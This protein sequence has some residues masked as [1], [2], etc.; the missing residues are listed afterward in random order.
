MKSSMSI[1]KR[2]IVWMLTAIILMNVIS[3]S[4]TFFS[5]DLVMSEAFNDESNVAMVALDEQFKFKDSSIQNY[6]RL[7]ASLNSDPTKEAQLAAGS[8]S[9]LDYVGKNLI[10]DN[11]VFAAYFDVSGKLVWS[12]GEL[13]DTIKSTQYTDK[14]EAYVDTKLKIYKACSASVFS[15]HV[16]VGYDI[17]NEETIEALAEAT[18]CAVT[19]FKDDIR[20][21]TTITNEA[22]EKVVGTAMDSKVKAVVIDGKQSFVDQIKLFGKQNTVAYEPIMDKAGNVIGAYFIGKDIQSINNTVTTFNIVLIVVAIIAVVA[23]AVVLVLIVKKYITGPLNAIKAAAEH[24]E[25]GHLNE[26]KAVVQRMDEFGQMTV[27]INNTAEAMRTYISDISDILKHIEEGDLRYSTDTVYHGDFKQ[28]KESIE[29]I[30]S[31][32]AQVMTSIGDASEQVRGNSNQI[33]TASQMLAEGTATQ[34]ATVQELSSTVADLSDRVNDNAQ[35]T[36][37]AKNLS[38]KTNARVNDQNE[39][40]TNMLA[41]MNDIKE[42]SNEIQK[43]IKSIDDIAFQTNILSLNAAVEAARA[44]AAGKGF[45]VVAEEVRNLAIKSAEAAKETTQYIEASINAVTDGVQLAEDAASS[46][47]EVMT[48]SEETNAIIMDIS[49]KTEEQATALKEVSVGLEQISD[50]VQQNSATA[51]ENAAS[52]ADLDAQAQQLNDLIA[53]FDV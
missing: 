21:A 22:G 39:K 26:E 24:I 53:K 14:V 18:G 8:F 1:G 28:I 9:S 34:A 17:T 13:P 48:I 12:M 42:K 6:G 10:N 19:I 50:V 38:D 16:V 40:M 33:S 25:H 3:L 36:M 30:C 15:A 46:L 5:N 23:V 45:A 35:N 29:S 31:N 11:T 47:S 4:I 43:I 51:E 37:Q 2:S 32:L 7:F 27:T 52:C 41:A 20:V 44:G 49:Q